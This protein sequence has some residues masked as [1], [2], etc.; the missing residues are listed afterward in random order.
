ML[1]S[2]SLREVLEKHSIFEKV[3]SDKSDDESTLSQASQLIHISS[4]NFFI[5]ENKRSCLLSTNLRD[6]LTNESE[7]IQVPN[8]QEL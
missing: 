1:S 3:W 5:W 2:I 7:K 8:C 4:S 6:A